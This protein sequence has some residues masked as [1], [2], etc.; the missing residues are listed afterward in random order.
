MAVVILVLTAASYGLY[1][2]M[3]REVKTLDQGARQKL[4][5]A[6]ISLPLGLTHYELT[7]PAGGPVVVLVHGA[8][9]P[10]WGWDRQVPA[11]TGAGFR[12][13]RYDH[14]GRGFSDRPRVKYDRSLYV[15]QLDQLLTA[16]KIK[17]PVDLVGLSMGGPIAGMFTVRRPGLVRRLAL[18][19]PMVDGSAGGAKIKL[20][21]PPVIGEFLARTVAVPSIVKRAESLMSKDEAGRKALSLFREQTLYQGFERSMLSLFRGDMFSH[22]FLKAYAKLQKMDL[23]VM[24]VWGTKDTDISPES[25]ESLRRVVPKVRFE[26]LENRGHGLVSEAADEV[27]QRLLDF[28]MSE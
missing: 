28:F 16:L 22:D 7:G 3:D 26:V 24:V 21:Q 14:F 17:G 11:L 12:V 9:V 5:G 20:L 27:N 2:W 18:I 8:T 25:I 23:P 1:I 4:G 6:Y 19:A 15:S 13:L 10:F